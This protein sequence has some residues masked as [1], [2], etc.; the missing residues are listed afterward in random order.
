MVFFTFPLPIARGK[1]TQKKSKKQRK[2]KK[3]DPF[4]RNVHVTYKNMLKRDLPVGLAFE[5]RAN[6]DL[7]TVRL[8]DTP[9]GF[10]TPDQYF[11][12]IR[13]DGGVDGVRLV[14]VRT[15][16]GKPCVIQAK[17]RPNTPIECSD[18][19][20]FL[21]VVRFLREEEASTHSNTEFVY[22]VSSRTS[23]RSGAK[24]LLEKFGVRIKVIDVEDDSDDEEVPVF[25]KKASSSASSSSSS[26]SV[27]SSS[28]RVVDPSLFTASQR[29]ALSLGQAFF[30]DESKK[31]WVLQAVGG[32]GKS[33]LARALVQSCCGNAKVLLLSNSRHL[34]DQLI[35]A[36]RGFSNVVCMTYQGL[37]AAIKNGASFDYDVVF[38][39]E[40][41]HLDE[42]NKW[43]SS[44]AS[45]FFCEEEEE[46]DS[47]AAEADADDEAADAAEAEAAEAEAAEVAKVFGIAK[48]IVYMSALFEKRTP[49]F[50]VDYA[51][52][53]GEKR[54]VDYQVHVVKL[55]NAVSNARPVEVASFLNS[56]TEILLGKLTIVFWSTT[57][58][59]KQASE[60]CSALGIVSASLSRGEDVFV[61][62]KFAGKK[63]LPELDKLD[64]IHVCGMLNEGVDI[65]FASTILFGDDR[66]A[67]KNGYQCMLRGS[68][69]CLPK[70]HFNIVCFCSSASDSIGVG[71]ISHMAMIDKTR[72]GSYF[73]SDDIQTKMNELRASRRVVVHVQKP[74]PDSDD[75]KIFDRDE[76]EKAAFSL[77][78]SATR[79][80]VR[81]D[82][83]SEMHTI[84]KARA[85]WICSR[86]KT[87]QKNHPSVQLSYSYLGATKLHDWKKPGLF[88]DKA[89]S[90]AKGNKV[91][92]K[93]PAFIMDDLK[94]WKF[95]DLGYGPSKL[96]AWIDKNERL[97][98]SQGG[99]NKRKREEGGEASSSSAADAADEA[100]LEEEGK[101][102]DI[103]D[104]YSKKGKA[105]I[106]DELVGCSKFEEH[107]NKRQVNETQR[108]KSARILN[109]LALLPNPPQ[110]SNNKVLYDIWNHICK[111]VTSV[112]NQHPIRSVS[113]TGGEGAWK[114]IDAANAAYKEDRKKK[115]A[116]SKKA[117]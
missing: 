54:I 59:A 16:N 64:I 92:N 41:H 63:L 81:G 58:R 33:S 38:A 68:R 107:F 73:E 18:A 71:A 52:A 98:E 51:A 108:E 82:G 80:Q 109:E 17:D 72:L 25:R 67:I 3:M 79:A 88:L 35:D 100:L 48:K 45:L 22:V 70:N 93:I 15:S 31:E 53:V 36:F 76:E 65:P 34:C 4:V 9:I 37:L 74:P 116:A 24:E 11:G 85:D 14:F 103:M 83:L 117:K 84:F 28:R 105:S 39:D 77:L 29:Q 91:T 89:R 87:V 23:I 21:F 47:D 57:K 115:W 5:L 69:V 75:S 94:M 62:N 6:I 114:E 86:T 27:S 99:K 96:R 110:S 10:F 50:V 46:E 49:D 44:V 101:M 42:D 95:F 26:S 97:P 19:R 102:Y 106:P 32:W 8:C 112:P 56:Q 61:Q 30:A 111:G 90:I 20:D 7:G 12:S 113:W 66:A 104:R 2:K 78:Y 60:A 40:A 43:S 13:G 1:A 55:R